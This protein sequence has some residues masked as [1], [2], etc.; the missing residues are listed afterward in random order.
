MEFSFSSTVPRQL[1]HR[2]SVGDVFLTDYRLETS[3]NPDQVA[4][5][6][7]M[8]HRFF[9]PARQRHDPLAVAESFRQA[10]ILMCHQKLE[11]PSQF[12]FLMEQFEFEIFGE[13]HVRATPMQLIIDMK[14]TPIKY[15][16]G[17]ASK[18][19]VTGVVHEGP[20]LIA[21]CHSVVRCVTSDVYRR[22][23]RDRDMY[24][25][26]SRDLP[27]DS[28]IIPADYVGR[29]EEEDVIVC[30]DQLKQKLYCAPDPMNHALFDH[31]V[32]H[33]PGMVLF[34]AAIQAVRYHRKSP[35]VQLV[36]VSAVFPAFAEWYVPCE[37]EIIEDSFRNEEGA[38]CL[39]FTQGGVVNA[40]FQVLTRPI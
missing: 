21:R 39:I 17:I 20:K 26:R 24:I 27:P 3:A 4:A 15:Y 8:A 6:V 12:K 38:A 7:P 37:L 36:S 34:G 32:D 18:V 22:I 25:A 19:K 28:A 31:P 35:M 5:Q 10:V 11:I 23:R 14:L 1:V 9:R 13:L 29:F 40:Q 16:D 2:H 33:I 30:V